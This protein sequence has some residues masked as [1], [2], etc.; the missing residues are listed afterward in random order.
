[1]ETL[2]PPPLLLL[3]LALSVKPLTASTL[4]IGIG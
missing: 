1:M 2:Q 3:S 4:T